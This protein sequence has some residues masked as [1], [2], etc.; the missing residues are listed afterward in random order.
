MPTP[1]RDRAA[2]ERRQPA[3]FTTLVSPHVHF[4]MAFSRPGA[5][6]APSSASSM[7]TSFATPRVMVRWWSMPCGPSVLH[8]FCRASLVLDRACSGVRGGTN[9]TACRQSRCRRSKNASRTSLFSEL[10]S[11]WSPAGRSISCPASSARNAVWQNRVLSLCHTRVAL[12]C[13]APRRSLRNKWRSIVNRPSTC[14]ASA[15]QSTRERLK[16][17]SRD[18]EANDDRRDGHPPPV[19]AERWLSA[20]T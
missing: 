19:L 6:P 10:S 12:S 8:Q 2:D 9:R 15:P 5:S 18:T 4:R 7:R 11:H 16:S 13:A 1:Q 17:E 3:D 20:K 14:G